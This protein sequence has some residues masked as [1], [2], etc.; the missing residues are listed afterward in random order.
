MILYASRKAKA[1]GRQRSGYLRQAHF[2]T[3][4][5]K[6]GMRPVGRNKLSTIMIDNFFR[7]KRI[8][9]RYQVKR[10]NAWI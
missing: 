2:I 3:T 9:V 6:G 7:V 8:L 10:V 1:L 5:K 4:S